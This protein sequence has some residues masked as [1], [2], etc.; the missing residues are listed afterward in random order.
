MLSTFLLSFS[1]FTKLDPQSHIIPVERDMVTISPRGDTMS[2]V[3]DFHLTS[4]LVQIWIKSV[5][6]K[7][8]NVSPSDV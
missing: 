2:S 8:A 7:T 6:K 4:Y 3:F 5:D 1:F